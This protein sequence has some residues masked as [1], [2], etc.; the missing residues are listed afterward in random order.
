MK[1]KKLQPENYGIY[2]GV[3]WVPSTTELNVVMGE[4]ESGK[5]T[6]LRFIRDMMFGYERG[7]WMGRRGHMEF[8]HDEKIYRIHRQ[9]KNK[10]IESE[11]GEHMEEEMA[12]LWWNGLTRTLY[13]KI[14]ALGL[15]DLQGAGFFF[16]DSVQSKFFMLQGGG[17]IIE[18]K[19]AVTADKEKRLIASTQGKRKIN[20][21]LHNLEKVNEDIEKLGTQEKD[22]SRLQQ[23]ERR[24]K[25][26]IRQKEI[27]RKNAEK[28]KKYIEKYMAVRDD[29]RRSQ[30]LK[31]QIDA[32]E[33][34]KIFPEH[35]KDRWNEI[36][37]K[38]KVIDDQKKAI[39]EK[40]ATYTPKRKSEIIPWSDLADDLEDLY[41]HLGQWKQITLDLLELKEEKEKWRRSLVA[42][43]YALSLW[44][45]PLVPGDIN[46]NIDW[47][48][49]RRLAQSVSVRENELHFWE[50][51]E[52]HIETLEKNTGHTPA[53]ATEKE[54]RAYETQA[55]RLEA[56]IH[57][58]AKEQETYKTLTGKEQSTYTRW[59]WIG[60]LL[61]LTTLGN[62]ALFYLSWMGYGALYGA[63]GTFTGGLLAFLLH[64]NVHRRRH[65]KVQQLKETIETLKEEKRNIITII[66]D[67]APKD[68]NDLSAFHNIMQEKRSEFYT[69]QGE[70][71]A[72]AWKKETIKK[73]KADHEA[74]EQEG[75]TL[76]ES[77]EAVKKEW[78]TW[79]GENHLPP[80]TA[81]KL[82]NLQE[83]WQKIAAEEAKGKIRDVRIG[84]LE[85]QNQYFYQK[86]ETIIKASGRHTLITPENMADMY[87]ENKK[88]NLEWQ[89]VAE[90]N[91]QHDLY[92]EER[93][94][95]EE[96]WDLC[97]K[98]L[99]ALFALVDAADADEFVMK[100]NAFENHD[101]LVDEWKQIEDHI[102]ALAGDESTFEKLR[103]DLEKGDNTWQ[104]RQEK[105]KKTIETIENDIGRLQQKQG[106]VSHEIL[107][108]ADDDTITKTLQKKKEIEADLDK[109]IDHWLTD[110]IVEK[111]LEKTGTCYESGKQPEIIQTANRFLKDMTQG[112][113]SILVDEEGKD[114]H[115]MDENHVTKPARIWSSGTGDQVYLALRLAMAISFGKQIE[116]LPIVLDDIFVR[117]DET[118]QKETLAFLLELGQREQIFLFTCHQRT[119]EIAQAIGKEKGRGHFV[120]LTQGHIENIA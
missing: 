71:Q 53:I 73:Q 72:L 94:K 50:K 108:L 80:V 102:K 60:S 114:I 112:K 70:Q 101:R 6:L 88:M 78:D 21:I 38:M 65:K 98:D 86:A 16:N 41:L 77:L 84:G 8:L 93:A 31:K 69:Y 97:Q 43:G 58:E 33:A 19:K 103:K 100:I 116:P 10:W 4:N 37:Q 15:E 52:P 54:W 51:R 46:E 79:T 75:Q 83:Q 120:K 104:E 113:Y 28:E 109:E 18:A 105:W 59:F 62:L 20:E 30:D 24:L 14:F 76:K 91:R 57:E 115:I 67:N 92:C 49:G 85:E 17:K 32:G 95:L 107:Q 34:I 45:K 9:E 117:F 22:F 110:L 82:S 56:L 3:T 63:I 48:E 90:K 25:E 7:Q 87:E 42:L 40:I 118:R 66:G 1:I 11:K 64:Q 36:I 26:E 2:H 13:E 5:T 27:D 29:Y 74:W 89:T 119:M 68:E 12:T 39:E 47:E 81:D 99:E 61:F 23:E 44:D 96:E 55:E 111:I 106:A 35:G